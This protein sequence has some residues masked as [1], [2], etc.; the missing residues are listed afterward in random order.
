[1]RRGL[2]RSMLFVAG[3]VPLLVRGACFGQIVFIPGPQRT[4]PTGPQFA[5]VA[6]FDGDGI[7]DAVV[8]NS[9]ARK[10]SVLFGSSEG[11]FRSAVDIPVGRSPR[12]VTTGDFN[13]DL[14]QDIAVVDPSLN[15]VFLLLGNGDGTFLSGGGFRVDRRGPQ[16][17]AT[18]NFDEQNGPDL[19]TAN[20]FAN[21][22]TTLLNLGGNRGFRIQP[23]L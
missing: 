10:V 6:D 17:V 9:T 1:M 11:V 4:V 5:A 22:I 7:Q 20:G 12:G 8:S 14:K 16:A 2:F 18:G 19:V 3:C 15:R 21:T 23:N 13:L